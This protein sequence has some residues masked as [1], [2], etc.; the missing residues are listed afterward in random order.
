MCSATPAHGR[1][2]TALSHRIT[3][4]GT[5][6]AACTAI[7]DV[8]TTVGKRGHGSTE[9]AS[10]ATELAARDTLSLGTTTVRRETCRPHRVG[11]T[12]KEDPIRATVSVKGR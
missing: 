2:R 4:A 8:V 12:D 10:A 1:E 6:L 3:R 7:R 11:T 5:S 9:G